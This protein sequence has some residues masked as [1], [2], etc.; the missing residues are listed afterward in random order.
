MAPASINSSRPS[1]RYAPAEIPNGFGS[2]RTQYEVIDVDDLPGAG[3]TENFVYREIGRAEGSRPVYNKAFPKV[4]TIAGIRMD[5]LQSLWP[6]ISG[7]TP[8][9]RPQDLTPA[10]RAQFY[11]ALLDRAFRDADGHA[12]LEAIKHRG[13]AALVADTI[14]REGAKGMETIQ[15]AINA[16][17]GE[18]LVNPDG[19]FGRESLDALNAVIHDA[20]RR[21]FFVRQIKLMR[22]ETHANPNTWKG[23]AFRTQRLY[24]LA[25][26]RN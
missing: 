9:T 6:R 12:T 26:G 14:F 2:G 1:V 15:N 3:P 5:D 25:T 13:V 23:E 22:D 11:R 17:A 21:Q 20:G 8:A 16:V 19:H 4:P 7:A 24:E 10:Q 18:K